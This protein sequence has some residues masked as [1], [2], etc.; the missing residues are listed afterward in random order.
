MT[1]DFF[2]T[3]ANLIE[4]QLPSHKIDGRDVWPIISR[5]P[6]AK[7]PHTAYWFYYEVNQLQ[8]VT[9]S[10]GRWKLQL[11]QTYRTMIGQKPGRDGLPGN[12]VNRELTK[13]KLYDLVNDV[14]ETT[15]VSSK[16]PEVVKQ[17]NAE[18]EKARADLGDALRKRPGSGQREPGRV[19]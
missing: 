16:H 15:D 14:G 1:I 12:Y 9:T 13:A 3:I 8:A 4:A 10:D 7:N 6:G 19:N 2:P 11:P 5:Q 17:L 18:A